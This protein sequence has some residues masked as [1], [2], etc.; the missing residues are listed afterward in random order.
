MRRI[1]RDLEAG[2]RLL[3]ACVEGPMS[4][5]AAVDQY[6]GMDKSRRAEENNAAIQYI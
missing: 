6:I 1:D 4:L 3:K 2:V 5:A